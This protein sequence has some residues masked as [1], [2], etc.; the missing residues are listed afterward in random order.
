MR[1]PSATN[2]IQLISG[3]GFQAAKEILPRKY[4]TG[5]K[6]SLCPWR[7]PGCLREEEGDRGVRSLPWGHR[8][9]RRKASL[10]PNPL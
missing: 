1:I 4:A 6:L 2:R 8:A 3:F 10:G 5:M 9:R 7:S